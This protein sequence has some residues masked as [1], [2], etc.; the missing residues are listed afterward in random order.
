MEPLIK[1]NGCNNQI[2]AKLT[3]CLDRLT[4]FDISMQNLTGTNLKCFD[5]LSRNSEGGATR[6]KNN[7]N[8]D[9]VNNIKTVQA[10]LNLEFDPK[11]AR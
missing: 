8:E 4:Q 7:H 3:R 1:R 6:D 11:F 2:S 10:E 5:Y 9:Y